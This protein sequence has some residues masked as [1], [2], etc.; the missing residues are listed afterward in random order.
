MTD[1]ASI[2]LSHGFQFHNW[3][4]P[5]E[6]AAAHFGLSHAVVVPPNTRTIIVGGQLG[7]CEDGS[8]PADLTEE[9]EVAFEHVEKSLRAAGLGDNAW[10]HVYSITTYEV[11]K[12]GQGIGSVVVP[13]ARKHLK[14]TRPAWTGVTVKGLAFPGLHLEITVQAYLPI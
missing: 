4:G 3:P 14:H 5:G 9:V 2:L 11:E 10:E 8:V 7:I 13:V 1:S 12:D 6:E